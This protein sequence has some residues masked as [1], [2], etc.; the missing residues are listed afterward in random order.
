MQQ[1]AIQKVIKDRGY[2]SKIR[3]G[4]VFTGGGAKLEGLDNY[5][6]SHFQSPSR[7]GSPKN[8]KGLEDFRG[9]TRYSTAVGLLLYRERELQKSSTKR[10]PSKIASLFNK[11]TKTLSNYFQK[12]L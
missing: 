7:I 10:H 12:E 4:L 6:E 8:I 5:A 11:F 9:K 1:V 3:A 2:A